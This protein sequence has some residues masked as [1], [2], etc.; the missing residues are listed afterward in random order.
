M[1]IKNSKMISQQ[2]R[3]YS[4]IY[5]KHR[6]FTISNL[7]NF[8]TVKFDFLSIEIKKKNFFIVLHLKLL[9]FLTSKIFSQFFLKSVLKKIFLFSN[10]LD[11]HLFY[12]HENS[13]LLHIIRSKILFY[14]YSLDT[15]NIKHLNLCVPSSYR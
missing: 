11:V 15:C 10:I 9:S 13:N 1:N 6:K 2:L 8:S 7:V 5:L 14:F 3:L 4:K 12:S